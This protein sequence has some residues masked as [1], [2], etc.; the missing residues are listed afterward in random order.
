M[1]I[2]LRGIAILSI[3]G[4][5]LANECLANVKS[6]NQK[7]GKDSVTVSLWKGKAPF[8]KYYGPEKII[9]PQKPGGIRLTNVSKPTITIFPLTGSASESHPAILICPGGGYT[10]LAYDLEGNYI[11]N[12]IRKMGIIPIVLKYRVPDQRKAAF[13]DVQRAMS[14]IRGHAKEWHI[15]PD[16]IGI[17][18]FSAGGNLAARLITHYKKKLYQKVDNLYDVS[19]KPDFSILIYPAYLVN[20]EDKLEEPVKIV[21]QPPPTFLTQ[22]QD[23]PIGYRNSLFFFNA[24]TKHH[25]PAEFHMFAHGGHGYGLT[26][27]KS[28]PLSNWP[29]LCERWLKSIKVIQ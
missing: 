19:I 13:A 27:S 24:L 12:W 6:K 29:N 18:G 20:K 22:T 26:T 2:Y 11:A 25:V 5:F 21:D 14:I 23:D 4:L 9:T 17:I 10:H 1:K 7:T 15:R 8:G 28:N 16:E 3:I